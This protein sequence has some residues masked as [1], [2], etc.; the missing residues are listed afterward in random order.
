MT[1]LEFFRF[2][3]HFRALEPVHFPRGKSGNAIR[4]AFGS[5]LRDTASAAVYARLFA[6]GAA[7]GESPGGL[8]DWPRPFVL[9][10]A[11]LNGA[12]FPVD[13]RFH[14]DVHVF[15]TRAPVLPYFRQAFAQL[16]ENGI[17]PRRGRVRL[18]RIEQVDLV[19]RAQPVTDEPHPPAV[20]ALDPDPS[21]VGR[22]CLR[23]VTPTEL[24]SDGVV[25]AR[26]EFPVLFGRLRDRIGAL[27]TLYGAGPLAIDF[28][29]M[30]DR[31]A[32]VRLCRAELTWEHVER[33][34]GRTGQV[35]P[36]GGFTGEAEYE[37]PLTEFL[38]WLHAARWC[39]VGRQTVWGKGDVR[40]IA[41]RNDVPPRP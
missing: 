14:F 36:L 27:R 5:A 11:A 13:S 30:G 29:A 6:P 15:D 20:I 28:R 1:T 3:F 16:A 7:L 25:A 38:P 12:T 32:G 22:V 26:P 37:G 34:S 40:V 24:K 35:H 33:K 10:A 41:P 23:F 17:G 9:R 39:G 21:P 31:A 18:E 4:G 8:A 19:D 2:R